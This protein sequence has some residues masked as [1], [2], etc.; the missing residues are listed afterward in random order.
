[1][2]PRIDVVHRRSD[3]P[4]TSAGSTSNDSSELTRAEPLLVPE[5]AVGRGVNMDVEV[6]GI[7]ETLVSDR[8][9]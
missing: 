6:D 1:M 5:C 4:A 3:S 8:R 7:L 9:R 2:D